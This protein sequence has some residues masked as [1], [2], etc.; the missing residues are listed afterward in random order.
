[1]KNEANKEKLLEYVCD[2]L[3]KYRDIAE[4]QDELDDICCECEITELVDR[5][6]GKES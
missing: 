3:C 2:R 6:A 1:M 5:L 4:D